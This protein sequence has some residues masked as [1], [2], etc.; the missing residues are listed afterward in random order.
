MPSC[1]MY[2]EVLSAG[3]AETL[4]HHPRHSPLRTT[5]TVCLN[6]YA[7]VLLP[8]PPIPPHVGPA[9]APRPG[10]CAWPSSGA[11]GGR[12]RRRSSMGAEPC[13]TG[14]WGQRRAG[15]VPPPGRAVLERA[16][17]VGRGGGAAGGR[18]RGRAPAGRA[19]GERR[20]MQGRA[21]HHGR[22]SHWE[23]GGDTGGPGDGVGLA[24]RGGRAPVRRG[25]AQLPGTCRRLNMWWG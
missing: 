16:E 23:T 1:T 19:A 22:R 10:G 17:G 4:A 14:W 3:C 12:R 6:P 11:A 25:V 2:G 7:T 18:R 8:Q 15:P 20:H 24:F 5:C 9:A 13:C 21:G